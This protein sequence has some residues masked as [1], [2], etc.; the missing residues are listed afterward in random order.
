MVLRSEPSAAISVM[1][2]L[3][4]TSSPPTH[5]CGKVG[6]IA[7]DCRSKPKVK[8]RGRGASDVGRLDRGGDGK[9]Y[10]RTGINSWEIEEDQQDDAEVEDSGSHGCGS[11]ST[12]GLGSGFAEEDVGFLDMNCLDLMCGNCH[13]QDEERGLSSLSMFNPIAESDE[14]SESSD[15]E[16][17][18]GKEQTGVDE[19]MVRTAEQEKVIEAFAVSHA[20]VAMSLPH[21]APEQRSGMVLATDGTVDG[22]PDAWSVFLTL[23]GR[24]A[25]PPWKPSSS[26][27]EPGTAWS[28][29]SYLGNPVLKMAQPWW[30]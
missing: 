3:P 13:I 23:R 27:E 16:S 7:K 21:A 20:K 15:E 14:G 24:V 1:M 22:L 25:G 26:N 17:D 11:L 5:N 4:P 18:S 12:V 19:V 2:S 10:R 8:E 9:W 28:P 30:R 6:H 29:P